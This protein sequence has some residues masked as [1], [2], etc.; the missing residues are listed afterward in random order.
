M[1]REGVVQGAVDFVRE[2]DDVS[3]FG[4]GN[5]LGEDWGWDGAAGWV[6]WVVDDYQLGAGR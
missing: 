5:D 6:V 2:E 4:E 1:G 3:L